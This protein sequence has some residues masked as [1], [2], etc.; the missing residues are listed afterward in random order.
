MAA[1]L[2]RT[3][4]GTP[5]PGSGSTCAPAHPAEP[6]QS[7]GLYP[8]LLRRPSAEHVMAPHQGHPSGASAPASQVLLLPPQPHPSDASH[9]TGVYPAQA[10]PV[11]GP[12]PPPAHEELHLHKHQ[13]NNKQRY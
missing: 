3:A 2:P 1:A 6:S 10:A 5:R 13:T 11:P 8:H 9:P 7:D 4:P 12:C